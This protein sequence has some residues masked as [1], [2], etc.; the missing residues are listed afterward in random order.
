MYS[1]SLKA[2]LAKVDGKF[3]ITDTI[4]VYEVNEVGARI[5]DLCNGK[6]TVEDI[7]IVL[8]K[9]YGVNEEIVLED[10]KNYVSILLNK[11]FILKN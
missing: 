8:A 6:N 5:F 2:Y 11:N 4:D 1:K 3:I 7:A 9:K 10:V